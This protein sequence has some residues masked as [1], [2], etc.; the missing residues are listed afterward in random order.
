MSNFV[1]PRA[2]LRSYRAEFAKSR[3]GD[4][5]AK[6][7]RGHIRVTNLLDRFNS[8]FETVSACFGNNFPSYTITTN[9]V[10]ALDD[11]ASVE[12]QA[13]HSDDSHTASADDEVV[14]LPSSILSSF[15]SPEEKKLAYDDSVFSQLVAL[16]LRLRRAQADASLE[17][18]RHSLGYRSFLY[19]DKRQQGTSQTTG[20]I[21]LRTI[22]SAQRKVD[23][24]ATTYRTCY[25]ALLRLG[26]AKDDPRY[27]PLARS[28]LRPLVVTT[29]KHSIRLELKVDK[30][31][32]WIWRVPGAKFIDED[33]NLK[34]SW[35]MEGEFV[36]YCLFSCAHALSR[37]HPYSV[38]GSSFKAE[39][40][41]GRAADL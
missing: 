1:I 20:P 2:I 6:I 5:E 15:N 26:L 32:A 8:L 41:V 16:E 31:S 17:S 30:E 24:H 4:A 25:A 39:S 3:S 34:S 13:T 27:K 37:S 33:G 38:A 18:I 12:D 10:P 9:A 28:D 21:A 23:R 35:Y 14:Q 7:Q 11:A 22:A 19:D 29:R 36:L 40:S